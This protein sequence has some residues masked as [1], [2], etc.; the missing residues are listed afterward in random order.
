ME[1]APIIIINITIAEKQIN[2]RGVIIM[3]DKILL[4]GILSESL[5]NG[6]GLRFVLFSQICKHNCSGCFNPETH[7]EAGGE[8]FDL[9]EIIKQIKTNP[10]INGVTFSGGDPFEQADKFAYIAKS[11]RSK[12]FT[13]WCYTGYTYE[14]IMQN[15]HIQKGWDDLLNNIDILIDGPF[16]EEHYNP[17]LKYR[18]SSNQ[19]MINVPSSLAQNKMITVEF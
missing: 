13:V 14:Y 9:S 18:G 10:I 7:S 2:Q 15:K 17:N 6:E 8:W 5:V 19:R 11:I 3:T 16:Q 1:S 4:A 12:N